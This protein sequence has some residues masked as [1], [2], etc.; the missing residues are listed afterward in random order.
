MS[1]LIKYREFTSYNGL[2]RTVMFLG[3]PL[4]SAVGLLVLSVLTMFIVMSFVDGIFGF[5]FVL[6]W[7]P[8][9]LFLRQISQEDDKATDILLLEIKYRLKRKGYAFFGNTLTFVPERYLRYKQVNEQYFIAPK[10][11]VKGV[12]RDGDN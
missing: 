1:T 9:G 4:L 5:L 3:L 6:I 11:T 7:L 12:E 8:V 10:E 2:D